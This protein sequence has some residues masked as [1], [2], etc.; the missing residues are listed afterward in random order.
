MAVSLFAAP[1]QFEVVQLGYHE[2]SKHHH[3]TDE[4]SGLSMNTE[5]D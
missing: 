2:N 4:A 5:L 3:S 1:N